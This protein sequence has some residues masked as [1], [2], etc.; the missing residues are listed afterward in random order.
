MC[1]CVPCIVGVTSCAY[2]GVFLGNHFFHCE[3]EGANVATLEYVPDVFSDGLENC[4]IP[5]PQKT[6]INPTILAAI[7]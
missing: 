7:T 6:H 4:R 2:V 5:I 1:V 3:W